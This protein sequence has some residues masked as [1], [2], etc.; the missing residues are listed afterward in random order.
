MS[1]HVHNIGEEFEARHLIN[2]ADATLPAS[3]DILLFH[4][5][6]VSGD[7]AAGDDL[8]ASADVTAITTEPTGSA[9][10]R[11]TVNLN[12]TDFTATQ[13]ASGD[14]AQ[15]ITATV[16]FDL[17]DSTG[18]QIDAYGIVISWDQDGDGTVEDHLWWTDTLDQAYDTGQHDTFEVSGMS[19]TRSGQTA[20]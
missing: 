8:A 16:Q 6:E 9:Y 15:E 1:T 17:S 18:T 10:A 3:V 2:D 11:Q 14:W 13:D 20:P 12:T 19:L 7:T 5:G 4:D